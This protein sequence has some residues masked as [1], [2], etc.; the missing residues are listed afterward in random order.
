MTA[1]LPAPRDKVRLALGISYNPMLLLAPLLL[2]LVGIVFTSF[3]PNFDAL[4]Q[5]YDY[6]TYYPSLFLTPTMF[7]AACFSRVSSCPAQCE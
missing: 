6:F 3:A 7:L 1:N 2:G 5:K 4:I